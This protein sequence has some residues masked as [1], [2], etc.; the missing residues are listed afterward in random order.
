VTSEIGSWSWMQY[1]EKDKNPMTGPDAD[2]HGNA[3]G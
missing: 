2:P 3:L 1:A